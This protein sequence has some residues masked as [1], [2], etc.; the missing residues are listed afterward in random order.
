MALTRPVTSGH[1][2]ERS[3]LRSERI[4]LKSRALSRALPLLSSQALEL[5]GL[6]LSKNFV[7]ARCEW[8]FHGHGA[9]REVSASTRPRPRQQVHVRLTR[10]HQ[11][12]SDSLRV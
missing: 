12:S 2:A 4:D 10:S 1:F 11:R 8:S 7:R 6:T 3:S 9:V 5:D